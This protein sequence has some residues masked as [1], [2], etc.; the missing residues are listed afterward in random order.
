M[1]PEGPDCD[2]AAGALRARALATQLGA[3]LIETHISW[4]LLAGEQ[5][6]K[7]K[8]PLRLPF[9]D[10]RTLEAR[11]RCCEDELRL[12]RRL[13][14]SIYR[15]VVPI[16]GSD[17]APVLGGDGPAIEFAVRMRRF[18]QSAL[19][20][21]RVRE[22]RLQAGEIDACARRLAR[23][24]LEAPAAAVGSG[25]GDP[26]AHAACA[27]AALLA[28]E[29]FARADEF[30]RLSSWIEGQSRVLMPHWAAR[31]RAGQVREC[32]GDLHLA[33]LLVLD[34][35]VMAFDGIEF[36]PALRW[37]DVI[38]DIAFPV[39]DLQAC[40]HGDL[41]FR[42]LNAWLDETGDHAGLRGLRH[43]LVYRALVRAQVE[44][45][46]GHADHARR[47]LEAALRWTRPTEPVVV[48][49]HGLPGSGK[50][51]VS[52]RLL[53]THGAIRLRS[54]VERKRLFGLAPTDDSRANG[55]DIYGPQATARTYSA[56]LERAALVL[57]AGFE[58]ILDAA[59]LRRAERQAAVALA[60]GR[61]LR[62]HIV[63]CEAPTEVLR[64]RLR[65]RRGDA[66]EADESTLT[67]LQS[68]V[69]PLQPDELTVARDPGALLEPHQAAAS[70]PTP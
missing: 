66:S 47:Y 20:S 12:N 18:P 52:Q 2:G 43:A 50:S 24:H 27:R 23:F 29:P 28:C 53:Q 16:T 3:T 31:L 60:T 62:C 70:L 48:L 61:G 63:H 40:G 55:L 6:Y 8:K 49:M 65:Q 68:V 67:L 30:D 57:D 34:G 25:F 1:H 36:D 56:L 17:A 14:P 26:A 58:A 39:M 64:E 42:L 5:A 7:L 4:V 69:E 54:D 59:F 51:F 15:S 35:E 9:V 45:L 32:H 38:E 10:Y 33:N 13:A 44:H 11:R 22:G 46:Q 37:I 21:A 19:F 41:A